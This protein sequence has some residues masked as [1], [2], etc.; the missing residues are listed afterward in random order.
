[1]AIDPARVKTLFLEASDLPSPE[2]R[3]AYLDRE[4]GGE[5]DLRARVE[6]LLAADDGAGRLSG[7]DVTGM[8]ETTAP[9]SEER[10][11]RPSRRRSP[12]RN[13]FQREADR[14][15]TVP[16]ARAH[17][18]PTAPADP[19]PARSSPAGTRCSTSSARGEWASLFCTFFGL[20]WPIQVFWA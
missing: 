6:T 13:R 14:T 12:R 10:A 2:E 15:A 3:A 16:R 5:P 20:Y 4:C 18:L 1:M 19:P 8:S 11:G 7:P 17:R 9:E